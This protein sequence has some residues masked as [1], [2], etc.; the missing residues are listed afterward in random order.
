MTATIA[1]DKVMQ[2]PPDKLQAFVGEW[3]GAKKANRDLDEWTF[4]VLRCLPIDRVD[5]LFSDGEL[6]V[7]GCGEPHSFDLELGYPRAILGVA[8]YCR[9]R[10][11]QPRKAPTGFG[12]WAKAMAEATPDWRCP[13]CDGNV[14]RGTNRHES[15]Y[16]SEGQCMECGGIFPLGDC[17]TEDDE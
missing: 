8:A 9:M 17:P 16:F 7:A 1:I 2:W 11:L 5:V 13:E 14:T 4:Y 3:V 6:M 12:R 15:P 10:G